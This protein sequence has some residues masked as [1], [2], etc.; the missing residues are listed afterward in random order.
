[1]V[2]LTESDYR[3]ALEVLRAACE[4]DGPLVFPEPVLEPL[5]ELV[6]CD[7]VTFHERSAR[8]DRVLVYTGRPVGELTPEIRTAHRCL[9]HQDPFRPAGGARTLSDFISPREYRRRELY[10]CVDRPLGVEHMMQLYL[11]PL[12]S[13]SRLEFDRAE[14]EFGERDRVVLD[15][16]LVHLRHFLRAASAE[17][18]GTAA[19][20]PRAPSDLSCRGRQDQRRDSSPARHLAQT[21]RKHLENAFETLGVHTRTAAVAAVF[22]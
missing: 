16:L 4:V 8:P 13:D 20:R 17:G 9:K 6:P 22:G 7:V 2:R 11:D 12:S 5:R 10:H 14:S 19:H 21:V 18:R 15:L 1:M 3:G